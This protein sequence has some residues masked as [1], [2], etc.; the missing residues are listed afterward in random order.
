MSM[1]RRRFLAASLA[2]SIAPTISGIA[3]S[4][5]AAARGVLNLVP[6]EP[7]K[8]HNYWCTW[9]TQNYM[10]GHDLPK[11]DATVLE[12]EQ[13][14]DLARASMTEQNV[15]AQ[16]GWADSFY[17]KIRNELFLLLDD[18]WESGGTAT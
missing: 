11:L 7:S 2:T 5:G 12:G 14:G 9:A 3:Q 18:G 6:P 16:G 10:Y 17:P 15:F 8:A 1:S 13:G 4:A